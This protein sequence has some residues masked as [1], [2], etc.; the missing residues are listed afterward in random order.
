MGDGIC[1]VQFL[2]PFSYKAS[3]RLP[4]IASISGLMEKNFHYQLCLF[5]NF[6]SLQN[7]ASLLV[8]WALARPPPATHLL[9]SAEGQFVPAH[10]LLH[11]GERPEWG[12]EG[13]VNRLSPLATEAQWKTLCTGC[14]LRRSIAY[15]HQTITKWPSRSSAQWLCNLG[16]PSQ[17]SSCQYKLPLAPVPP[18]RRRSL[19]PLGKKVRLNLSAEGEGGRRWGAVSGANEVKQSHQS[20]LPS[21]WKKWRRRRVDAALIKPTQSEIKTLE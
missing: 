16:S 18:P 9:W 12:G 10:H 6:K 17:N 21:K 7:L 20:D 13:R 15:G 4:I 1:P 5:R 8:F 3:W 19:Q 14:W 2:D 11:P